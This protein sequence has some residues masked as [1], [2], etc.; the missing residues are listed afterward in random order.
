MAASICLVSGSIRGPTPGLGVG[1][2]LAGGR[3]H[4]PARILRCPPFRAEVQLDLC[5]FSLNFIFSASIPNERHL[6]HLA[7]ACDTFHAIQDIA[8][9]NMDELKSL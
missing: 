3:D 1:D 7:I 9:H 5:N 8:V 2:S 4:L 6:Q